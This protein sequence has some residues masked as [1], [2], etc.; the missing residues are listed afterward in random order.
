[1]AAI[2]LAIGSGYD[3]R[4]VGRVTAMLDFSFGGSKQEQTA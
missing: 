3:H 2:D 4:Q 1:M